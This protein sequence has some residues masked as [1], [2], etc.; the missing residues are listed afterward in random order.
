MFY[1]QTH[2]RNSFFGVSHDAT[3][4][5]TVAEVELDPTSAT[6]ARNVARKVALPLRRG[7]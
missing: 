2:A 7:G 5:A 1:S 6:A 4:L 3:L